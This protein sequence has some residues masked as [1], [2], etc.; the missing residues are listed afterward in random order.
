MSQNFCTKF[1]L[2][3]SDANSKLPI[4]NFIRGSVLSPTTKRTTEI[5]IYIYIAPE[6]NENSSRRRIFAWVASISSALTE[7]QSFSVSC[8]VS[9]YYQQRVYARLDPSGW[10]MSGEWRLRVQERQ[11]G[12]T[13]ATSCQSTLLVRARDVGREKKRVSAGSVTGLESEYYTCSTCAT[14]VFFDSVR[15]SLGELHSR[16]MKCRANPKNI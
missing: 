2:S 15:V 13:D 5:Y 11:N 9:R 12:W 14:P 8:I 16:R 7:T 10:A 1:S 3:V 4:E 6:R